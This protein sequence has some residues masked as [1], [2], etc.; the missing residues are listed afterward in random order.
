MSLSQSVG[1]IARWAGAAVL[2]SLAGMAGAAGLMTPVTGGGELTLREQHVSVTV[3]NGYAVTEIEQVFGNPHARDLTAIYRFPVPEEAIVGEF[4]YWIDGQPV[5]AEVMEKQAAR[6]LHESEKQR[7]RE[8]AL[9][10]KDSYKAFQ[11]EVYPVRAQQTVRTRLVYLQ[12]ADIDHSVGRYVYPLEDGGTEPE[13][14]AF[15]TRN[16]SVTEAFSFD[17]TLRSAYPVDAVRVPRGQAQIRQLDS[18]HWEVSISQASGGQGAAVGQG[19]DDADLSAVAERESAA[20][21][22]NRGVVQAGPASSSVFTLD[23]D[24]VVY[25]RLAENLPGAVDLV[26]YRAP[27]ESLGTFML[28]L[29][30]GIDLQPITEGRDWVFV[31]DQSGSMQGKFGA[32]LS[33]VELA[34]GQL[35]PQDRFRVVMFNSAVNPLSPGFLP[36]DEA[37]VQRTLATLKGL[38]PDSGTNLHAG[39]DAALKSL[40]ADRTSAIVLVTDGVANLGSTEI[41]SFVIAFRQARCTPLYRRDGQRCQYAASR[42]ADHADRGL[43]GQCIQQR[44]YRRAVETDR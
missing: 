12:Q 26:T 42:H 34:L 4:T 5:H 24:I 35:N 20:G 3:D 1:R 15:W 32:L 8:T 44:R 7:G 23:S 2:Y 25:W 11:I 19:L 30:P 6:T 38:H 21:V 36:A 10:E 17:L 37:S 41:R 28:T 40:D 13:R 29:T 31:L 14:D 22:F 27:G 18:G 33:G 43:C 9:V 16:E 39:L